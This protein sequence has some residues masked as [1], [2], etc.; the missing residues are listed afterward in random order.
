LAVHIATIGEEFEVREPAALRHYVQELAG[1]LG[2]AT[3][4][5]TEG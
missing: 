4:R 1:R 3:Q 2:R 5:D